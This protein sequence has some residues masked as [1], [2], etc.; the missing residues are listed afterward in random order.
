MTYLEGLCLAIY[1]IYQDMG[2]IPAYRF[3]STANS[4]EDNMHMRREYLGADYVMIARELLAFWEESDQEDVPITHKDFAD[5]AFAVFEYG[6]F[7][8]QK[9]YAKKAKKKAAR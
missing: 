6:K 3:K 5:I 1:T 2:Y 8:A 9:R 7:D 4:M